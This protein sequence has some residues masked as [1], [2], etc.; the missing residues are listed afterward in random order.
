MS[1]NWLAM[2]ARLNA[3]GAPRKKQKVDP[4]PGGPMTQQPPPV[5][6]AAAAPPPKLPVSS[7]SSTLSIPIPRLQ[8]SPKPFCAAESALTGLLALDCEMVGVGAA[9]T[10]SVLAQ[11]VLVNS[12]EEL[13]YSA[14]VKPSETVTDFRTHVS[15]IRS[16]HFAHAIPF[17]QAQT[18]VAKLIY[19]RQIV[20]HAMHND[21]KALQLSHPKTSRRDTA[22]FTPFRTQTGVGSRARKL[23]ELAREK[24]GLV[25]QVGEHS[26]LEDAIAALRLYKL[27]AVEWERSHRGRKPSGGAAK[28]K[29]K[30]KVKA[31]AK[32]QATACNGHLAAVAK[33]TPTSGV[34]CAGGVGGV[35][36]GGSVL[37]VSSKAKPQAK[38]RNGPVAIVTTAEATPGTVAPV[39][40]AHD[41]PAV[42][43]AKAKS[44]SKTKGQVKASCQHVPPAVVTAQAASTGGSVRAVSAGSSSAGIAKTKRKSRGAKPQAKACLGPLA[45]AAI[46][47][48][49]LKGGVA[50]TGSSVG[51]VTGGGS[52]SAVSAG[53]A[54]A[55]VTKAK[56]KSKAKGQAKANGERVAAVATAKVTHAGGG[57]QVGAGSVGGA[58]A[59]G[60]GSSIAVSAASIGGLQPT[61]VKARAKAKRKRGLSIS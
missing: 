13:V 17:R 16:H 29:S 8:L 23:S 37:A 56:R 49:P 24:L 30:S 20:G 9:G 18:D 28:T 33:A 55:G 57:G 54:S 36:N 2:Q 5:S 42:S 44:T 38:A 22:M 39:A 59:T 43:V 58:S 21:F 53:P 27:H 10:R 34:A 7:S 11:V 25:I 40:T 51:G 32:A 48:V 12:R 60:G 45:A 46:A 41:T 15:G 35:L 61:Q 1:S 50:C 47:Q 4:K 26:P 3:D 31:Q 19:K 52:V 6:A 14:Y